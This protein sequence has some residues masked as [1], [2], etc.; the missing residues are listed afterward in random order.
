MRQE[1]KTYQYQPK[2]QP[3]LAEATKS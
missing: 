1:F 3:W 2:L